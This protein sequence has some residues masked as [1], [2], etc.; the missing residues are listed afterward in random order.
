MTSKP[1]AIIATVL[2]ALTACGTLDDEQSQFVTMPDHGWRYNDT[3]SFV[4][5]AADSTGPSEVTGR[6]VIAVRHSAAYRYSNLWVELSYNREGDSV[7]ARDTANIVLADVYGRW[8]GHGA[9]VSYVVT[10]T[11]PRRYSVRDSA[12]LSLRH[13]MRLDTVADIEQVGLIFIPD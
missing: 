9:G 11:L 10:D 12:S 8:L 7:P 13:I 6:I 3:L 5:L 1:A 2:M 4:P